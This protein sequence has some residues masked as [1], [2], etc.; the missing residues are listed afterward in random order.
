MIGAF[1]GGNNSGAPTTTAA[2]AETLEHVTAAPEQSAPAQPSETAGQQNAR[3]SAET[4][5]GTAAFSRSGLI[6]QLKFEGYSLADATYAVGAITV[7]WKEQAAK[8]AQTYLG[9]AAFSRSGL[10]KQ[11]KFEGYSLA[12]A[13][14]AV[15]AITVN[16]KEQAAKSARAYLDTSS[17][18]R[19]GLITQLRYEGFTPTQATYGVKVAY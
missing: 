3:E 9:T 10:I 8:S 5:L 2:R 12:D 7:N 1:A 17:F 13:T 14:Y 15:D 16:W 6:K 19:S 4:Y 18:S 11:L